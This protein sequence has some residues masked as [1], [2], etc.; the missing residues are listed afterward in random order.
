MFT[1][2]VTFCTF[3]VLSSLD[4]HATSQKSLGYLCRY[5]GQGEFSVDGMIFN[6][7]HKSRVLDRSDGVRGKVMTVMERRGRE[8]I[9]RKF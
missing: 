5:E 2:I 8:I 4:S 1:Q 3:P 7:F 9:K 6:L